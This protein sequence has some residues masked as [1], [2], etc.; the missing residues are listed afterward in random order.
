MIYGLNFW[1]QMMSNSYYYNVFDDINKFREFIYD[2][3]GENQ[4]LPSY[5][6]GTFDKGM[7]NAFITYS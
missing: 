5:A 1:R 6:K 4:T 3:R 7:I 2:L